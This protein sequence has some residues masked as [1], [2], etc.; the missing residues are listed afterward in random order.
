MSDNNTT[1]LQVTLSFDATRR[2]H[3]TCSK[4]DIQHD[5]GHIFTL[6]PKQ[7]RP[8]LLSKIS[9]VVSF[10]EMLQACSANLAKSVRGSAFA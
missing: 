7:R 10:G 4:L 5:S 2:K 9:V 6:A 3:D 8:L 1:I